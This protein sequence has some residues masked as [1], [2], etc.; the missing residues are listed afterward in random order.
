MRILPLLIAAILI[1]VGIKLVVGVIGFLFWPAVLA[2]AGY[3]VY[4]LIQGNQK[5][6]KR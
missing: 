1:I 5:H 6:L 3:G 4:K 2:L